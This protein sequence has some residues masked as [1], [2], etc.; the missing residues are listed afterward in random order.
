MPDRCEP[1]SIFI[2]RPVAG[3]RHRELKQ[4]SLLCRCMDTALA[5]ELARPLL[6]RGIA[7][8]A[9]CAEGEAS[10]NA[11]SWNAVSARYLMA[12][13]AASGLA[14]TIRTLAGDGVSNPFPRRDV[15]FGSMGVLPAGA[16]LASGYSEHT[17]DVT[18]RKGRYKTCFAA[19]SA[20]VRWSDERNYS[21]PGAVTSRLE[22][23]G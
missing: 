3:R 17:H 5:R 14:T 18:V 9:T 22:S 21:S 19:N 13:N 7:G 2:V 16:V 11:R 15:P 4:I 8:V 20:T 10:L 1:A 23:G 12:A 6:A